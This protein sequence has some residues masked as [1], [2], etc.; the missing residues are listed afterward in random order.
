MSA[1]LCPSS[2]ITAGKVTPE[3]PSPGTVGVFDI[4]VSSLGATGFGFAPAPQGQSGAQ[5][6][7]AKVQVNAAASS[8]QILRADVKTDQITVGL[9]GPAGS[10][11]TL[12][13]TLRGSSDVVLRNEA[14]GTGNHNISF[15]RANLPFR[16]LWRTVEATWDAAGT[17][18]QSARP[19]EIEA[20]GNI[21]FSRYNA[22]YESECSTGAAPAFIITHWLRPRNGTYNCQWFPTTLSSAFM[23][24]VFINGT[25]ISRDLGI[26]KSYDGGSPNSCPLQ[27]ELGMTNRNTFFSVPIV[28]GS[29]F[30]AVSDGAVAVNPAPDRSRGAPFIAERFTCSD[31][32]VVLNGNQT[33]SVR[34]VVDRCPDCKSDFRGADG[35]IDLFT[36]SKACT[37]RSPSVLD[38]G[39]FKAIRT[40]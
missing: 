27:P 31:Q 34:Q 39:T 18:V 30:K 28:D 11:G 8:V 22:P 38:Y 4:Q 5:S 19:V 37:P 6:N 13:V 7:R 9:S 29:C 33:D 10:S 20:L 40:R 23:S 12:R 24:Q 3:V 16:G 17:P 14:A 36:S 15:D 21:R 2:F 1:D 25:G 32:I 26:V 35:H